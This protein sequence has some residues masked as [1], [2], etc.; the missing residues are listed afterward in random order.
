M[1][2]YTITLLTPS[3][4]K[5]IQA[6]DDQYIL[7][8]AEKNKINLPFS[9]RAGVCGTCTGKLTQGSIDQSEQAVLDKDQIASGYVQLCVGYATTDCTIETHQSA[10]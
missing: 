4:S 2:V 8:V 5:T 7:D 9:C 10:D 1:A 6:P 3:G